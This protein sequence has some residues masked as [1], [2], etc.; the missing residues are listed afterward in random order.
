[1]KISFQIEQIAGTKKKKKY[2]FLLVTIKGSCVINVFLAC[3]KYPAQKK[4]CILRNP[5]NHNRDMLG[6][7]QHET[8]RWVRLK[9]HLVQHLFVHLSCFLRVAR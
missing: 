4:Q 3:T 5:E 9:I 1:M 6:Q 8:P 7:Q 2:Y